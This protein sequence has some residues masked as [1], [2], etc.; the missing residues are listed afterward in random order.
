MLNAFGERRVVVRTFD[1]GSDK[2][3]PFAR[4]EKED[5]PALGCRGIRL[6]R[7][8][9]DLIRDQLQALSNALKAVE[10]ANLWVVAPMI[11]TAEETQ[12]FIEL[13]RNYDLPKVGVMI[14]TPAAA[15][16][17]AEIMSIAD[18]ASVGT[19]DLAQYTMAADR[20]QGSLGSLT[21]PWQPAVQ[22]MVQM[23]VQGSA[24]R[25]KEVGVCGEAAG[26]PALAI[27]LASRGV[28]SLSMTLGNVPSVQARLNA[29]QR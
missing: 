7:V 14:E 17:S 15:I 18:F 23:A 5:N 4:Q 25:G 28:S 26:D 22:T 3:L 6:Y 1:A 24:S 2:P 29:I 11:T 20:A 21:G 9:E 27:A 19:N 13:A 10:L 8:R 16:M 12:W